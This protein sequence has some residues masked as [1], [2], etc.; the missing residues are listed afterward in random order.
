VLLKAFFGLL[1]A[2]ERRRLRITALLVLGVVSSAVAV[3][4]ALAFGNVIAVSVNL[5]D[6]R[7]SGAPEALRTVLGWSA[8][9]GPLLLW[10]V[11]TALADILRVTYG[12][13]VTRFFNRLVV[14]VRAALCLGVLDRTDR[15][16][17]DRTDV[18]YL[19]NADCQQLNA[20]YAVPM[21]TVFS[22]LLDTAIMTLVIAI[23]SWKLALILVIPAAPIYVIARRAGRAQ[24]RYAVQT[25]AAE[26]TL[27]AHA[28]AVT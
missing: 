28:T 22:D 2:A 19:I 15:G 5:L 20:L 27:N 11:L 1:E 25:R 8:A 24:N 17:S 3:L 10:A 6:S 13:Q 23:I 18:A 26:T 9:G 16:N 12:Y 4:A 21:T 14:D 7:N